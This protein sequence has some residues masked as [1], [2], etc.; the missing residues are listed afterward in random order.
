M[1]RPSE[2]RLMAWMTAMGVPSKGS[3]GEEAAAGK[4]N[5]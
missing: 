5:V 3:G 1:A 2:D 4:K